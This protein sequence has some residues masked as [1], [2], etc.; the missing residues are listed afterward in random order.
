MPPRTCFTPISVSS[1]VVLL[2]LGCGRTQESPERPPISP[3]P[4]PGHSPPTSL[5]HSPPDSPPPTVEIPA[6]LVLSAEGRAA[7]QTLSS[8]PHFGGWAVGAAGTPTPV[9]AS[10]RTL[11]AEPN[12]REAFGFAVSNGSLAGQLTALSGLFFTD[13]TRFRAELPRFRARR[14]TVPLL[15]AGCDPSGD[16][17]AV[18]TV[19]E[20]PN[21][22]QL[23]G[24][25]DDL[26]AWSQ[27]NPNR[28]IVY[29]IAGGS[30]PVVLRGR[31]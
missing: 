27:R 24:P 4:G 11:L 5:P 16:V 20:A 10:F 31:R 9:V 21:S 29:D 25:D 7:L 13:P 22:V 1:V 15:T 17:V 26:F 28:P 12:A 19:V 14:E 30:Y 18:A 23:S 6:G 3:G 2:V 8:A